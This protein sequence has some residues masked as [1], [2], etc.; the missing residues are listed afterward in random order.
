MLGTSDP[1]L[2]TAAVESLTRL[3][4]MRYGR[5]VVLWK[6]W[7]GTRNKDEPLAQPK[8]DRNGRRRYA[9]EIDDKPIRPYYFGLPVHGKKVVFVFDVSASMRYKLPLA[10]DQ[11]SRAVKALP[12]TSSFEVI[13]F[14]EHVWSWRGRLSFAD[15]VTKERLVRH[16]KTIEIKSYTN[17]YDSLE[18]A[19]G[20]GPDEIFV[21]SDGE[22]NRGRWRSARDI[23]RELKKLNARRTP[24]HTISVVRTVDGD[25]HVGL[26]RAIAEQHGGQAV[27]RTLK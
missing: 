18:K 7:W 15:P 13:F 19:I 6:T 24:I 14:N 10:Y 1:G 25:K 23:L 2:L 4:G 9:H 27:Q 17:L 5:D 22:P 12:S 21:I 3:T 20:L 11:L 8:P 16:L 26:L